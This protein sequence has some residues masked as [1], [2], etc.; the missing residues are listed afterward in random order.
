[1]GE[2]QKQHIEFARE[3]ASNFNTVCGK[4]VLVPP[5]IILCKYT[6]TQSSLLC[7]ITRCRETPLINRTTAPARRV[8]SLSK[9]TAKMSKSDPSPMSQILITDDAQQIRKKFSRALTD[10][11]TDIVSYD[12]AGRPGVSNLLE[13]L[14]ILECRTPTETAAQFD[15][16]QHPFKLLKERT[17]DAVTKELAGV[18]DRY[19]E[20]MTK[21]DGEALDGIEALGAEKARK[22]ADLTMRRVKDAVGL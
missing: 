3:C 17:A 20:L 6:I 15:G 2:D 10:S 4:A 9:P 1:M 12:R 19:R 5:E 16:M 22:N 21:N 11:Q 8:M 18:G 7:P 13:I 14:S